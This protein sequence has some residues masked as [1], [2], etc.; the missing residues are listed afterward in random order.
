[1]SNWDDTERR[2]H[3]SEVLKQIAKLRAIMEAHLIEEQ[4]L[5][6]HIKELVDILQKSKGI[7]L[8]FKFLLYVGAPI[9]AF[10]YWVKDHVKL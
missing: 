7:V 8:L 1:M 5:K 10:I 2:Q 3:D 9:G 6:P 4:Q